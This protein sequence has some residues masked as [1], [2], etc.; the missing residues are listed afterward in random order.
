[1][2]GCTGVPPV[3][4]G[5]VVEYR[6]RRYKVIEHQDPQDHPYRDR[7]PS[8]LTPH[9]PDGVAYTLWPVGVPRKFGN[10]HC[11]KAWVRR[12]SFRVV[13]GEGTP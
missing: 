6:G 11:M 9:Y 7:L 10:R 8:P 2:T 1:M 3:P 13:E 5:T 12:T 4:V